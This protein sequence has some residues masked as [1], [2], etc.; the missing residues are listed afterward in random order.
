MKILK[1]F[2]TQFGKQEYCKHTN[3]QQKRWMKLLLNHFGQLQFKLINQ[4]I[5]IQSHIPYTYQTMTVVYINFSCSKFIE[6]S[7]AVF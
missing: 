4:F 2:Q 7:D 6:E 5:L 1:I 3:Q